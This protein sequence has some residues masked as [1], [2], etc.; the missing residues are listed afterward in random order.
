MPSFCRCNSFRDVACLA[1]SVYESCMAHDN[2]FKPLDGTSS[3]LVL[4]HARSEHYISECMLQRLH[5][6]VHVVVI[7]LTVMRNQKVQ[8]LAEYRKYFLNI[9][10]DASESQSYPYLEHTSNGWMLRFHVLFSDLQ[11]R[12]GLL[13]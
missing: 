13:Y 7:M 12:Y 3:K 6:W 8:E 9:Q 5:Y 2:S 1:V 11:W 10:S 4:K